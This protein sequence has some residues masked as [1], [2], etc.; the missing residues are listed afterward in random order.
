MINGSIRCAQNDMF[1]APK[2]EQIVL[3]IYTVTSSYCLSVNRQS[4]TV[5]LHDWVIGTALYIELDKC[6]GEPF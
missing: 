3:Y 5:C 6:L 1:A 4:K 2:F